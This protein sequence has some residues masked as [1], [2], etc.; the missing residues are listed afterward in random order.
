MVRFELLSVCPETGARR[1]RLYTSHGT[2]ETPAFMPVG[3]QGT[4]KG[5]SAEELEG[6]GFELLLANTYHL[7]LRPG[8]E[9]VRRLGGIHRFMGWRGG[10]LTDSGGYQAMSLAGMRTIS[11]EGVTFRSHLDGSTLFLSPERAIEIQN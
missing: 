1:G 9:T 7:H 4:V 5:I 8:E 11:D 2:V 3:T 10:V 6:F